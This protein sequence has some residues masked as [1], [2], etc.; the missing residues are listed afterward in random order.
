MEKTP[1]YKEHGTR[2]PRDPDVDVEKLALG[3]HEKEARRR[4]PI[5]D[6]PAP[7]GRDR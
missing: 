2:D 4:E 1:K 6:E 3:D 5:E 7:Q